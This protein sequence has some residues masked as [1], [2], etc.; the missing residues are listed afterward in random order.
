MNGMRIDDTLAAA[1]W[2]RR[3]PPPEGS[4]AQDA[5]EVSGGVIRDVVLCLAG[6]ALLVVSAKINLPLRPMP[7]TLMTLAIICLGTAYG[8]WLST[9]SILAYLV[10]GLCGLPVFA[11]TPL[12]AA[13]P[14]YFLGPSG[15]FLIGLVPAAMIMGF[16]AENG[17]DRKF[18]DSLPCALLAN[19]VII[20]FALAWLAFVARSGV[21]GHGLGLGTAWSKG[22]AP[23]FLSTAIQATLA[24]AIFPA[25][26]MLIGRRAPN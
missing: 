5:T 6:A 26:W 19:A 14:A 4:T 15:G 13:G 24:A 10:C 12:V 8:V 25:L 9:L 18:E 11:H 23:I 22:I 20:V 3:M 1:I 17:L 2:P 16:A 21:A 7:M